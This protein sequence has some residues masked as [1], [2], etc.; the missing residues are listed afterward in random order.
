MPVAHASWQSYV[1]RLSL[2]KSKCQERLFRRLWVKSRTDIGQSPKLLGFRAP[3]PLLKVPVTS[4][5]PSP[6]SPA[7]GF[8]GTVLIVAAFAGFSIFYG[9]RINLNLFAVAMFAVLIGLSMN[10]L[11]RSAA[12]PLAKK[13]REF[14]CSTCFS[15]RDTD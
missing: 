13:P 1:L 14:L 7:Q 9:A 11:A 2:G 5:N 10:R 15:P 3:A 6:L 4:Y 8:I 12:K